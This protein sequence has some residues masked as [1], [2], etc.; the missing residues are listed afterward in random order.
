MSPP[1]Q[2]SSVERFEDLY[3]AHA[4]KVLASAA[5]VSLEFAGDAT[6]HAFEEAWKRMSRPGGPPV[7]NW[8]GWLRRTAIRRVVEECRQAERGSPLEGVDPPATG[9]LS[10]D[11]A[12]IRQSFKGTLQQIAAL[13]DRQR[14]A[15]GLCFLAGFTTQETA[16]IMEVTVSTVRN[17]VSQARRSLHQTDGEGRP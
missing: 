12:V 16:E 8:A 13:P 7:D 17:L 4:R 9:L 11:W 10:E 3:R 5:T 2:Q 1:E 15:L 6:Q 14:Q